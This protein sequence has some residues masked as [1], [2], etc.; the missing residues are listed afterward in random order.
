MQTEQDRKGE[1]KSKIVSG[2]FWRFMERSGT[3]GIQFFVSIILAR[4]LLP[5]D[6]GL[7][8]LI[9]VF[10]AIANVFIQSGFGAALIQKKEVD[11][12]DY[13][14]VFYFSLVIS[15]VLY[16]ILFLLAPLI[17][18]F[19]AE[20]LFI[21]VLRVLAVSLFLGAINTVQ[22]A[23]ISRE[24]KFKKSFFVSI[25]G[26]LASGSVGITL[27]YRG[28]GVWSLVYSSLAG[29]LAAT[30]ILGCTV[31]WRPK[32]TFSFKKLGEMFDFGSKLLFS[33]LLD[34]AFN[35]LYTL[36]IGKLYNQ[37]T[38]GYYN[39]AQS[40]PA[41][42]ANNLDGTITSVMFPALAS[43]QN[44]QRRLKEMM[45]RMMVTSAFLIMPMMFGLAVVARPM[46][47]ILLTEKWLPSVPFLQLLCF[48][49]AF[50]PL[51]TANLQAIMAIGRSDIFLKLE[52]LKKIL[53][54]AVVGATYAYGVYVMVAGSV[55]FSM[56]C[57]LINAWPNASLLDYSLTAQW[58][59]LMPTVLLSTAMCAVVMLISLLPVGIG[60]LLLLQIIS[61]VLFYFAAAYLLKYE[62]F[63]YLLRTVRSGR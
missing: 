39:R 46:V 20:P 11:E 58:R 47:V 17:A 8:G 24:M 31:R 32:L 50:L 62:C 6:F 33:A 49:F 7:I 38:L 21:R 15:L 18:G 40:M 22:N 60:P 25:G 2:L 52:I 41:F 51:H 14:S 10:I 54:L 57:T 16:L 63:F 23:V 48:Q 53:F 1:L 27:A 56:L 37:T 5:K 19:Y 3:Q 34:T 55:V 30:V 43:C 44:D 61:G 35:N 9:T 13:S 29:Q 28:Y 26:I 42:I 59:D 36:V 4:L 12:Q 45:R